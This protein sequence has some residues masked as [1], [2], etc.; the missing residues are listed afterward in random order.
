[1]SKVI[2]LC[3]K[4]HKITGL[5][6][7]CK[8][9]RDPY[10]YRGSGVFWKRHLKIHGSDHNTEII[11]ECKNSDE[12]REWGLHYSELWNI[13]ESDEW[14]NL[15]PESGD[16]G[17][18][19]EFIDYSSFSKMNSGK[20]NPMYGSVGGMAGKTHTKETIIQQKESH[21]KVWENMSVEKRK[22]RS[23]AVTGNKNAMYGNQPTNNP[24]HK[25]EIDGVIYDSIRQASKITG[26]SVH[27]I[28]RNG[29]I[30]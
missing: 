15:R 21:R 3:V 6:Y 7:L 1:M 19:S 13:V 24:G 10:K 17:D 23:A 25:V 30:L 16:G 2:Y 9:T 28:K 26:I 22:E 5:K 14:A 27:F 18:T 11:K 4:T 12:I 8:T 29:K 20:N